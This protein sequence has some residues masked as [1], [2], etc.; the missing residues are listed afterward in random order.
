MKRILAF[1]IL[2]TSLFVLPAVAQDEALLPK[3]DFSD[4]TLEGT[5]EIIQIIDPL[6]LQLHDGSLVALT[7]LDF[8]DFDVHESG[9]FAL[10]ARNILQ[11]VVGGEAVNIYQ[12]KRADWGRVNRM[13]HH[14]TQMERKKDSAWVQGTLL[15]LG[16]ARVMT[17]QRNPEMA[18]QMYALEQKAREAKTGLWESGAYAVLTPE[19]TPDHLDSFQI[20]EGTIVSA[21]IKYNRVYLN[22]GADWRKDFTVSIAPADKRIFLKQGIDPLA[23]N[24]ETVRVRGWLREYNG[25]YMEIDHPEALERPGK[26][27]T[28]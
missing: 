17:T 27:M 9:D 19:Q 20:V 4:L 14:L 26:K 15:S 11:D 13:G 5:A 12:T 18:E 23:L 8:P 25:P 22:F 3:G 21:S 16:L 2:L 10:V 1:F 6:T 24:G 28:E 7:G